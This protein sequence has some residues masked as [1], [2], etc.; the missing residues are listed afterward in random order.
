MTADPAREGEG[1]YLLGTED[2]ELRRLAFQ[3]RVWLRQAIELWERAGFGTGQ[4]LLDLGCGPGFAAIDLAHWVGP[5]GRIVAVDASRRFLDHLAAH[6]AAQGLGWIERVESD[7]YDL[8]LDEASLDGAYCRW[9]FCFLERPEAVLATL[10]RALRPGASLAI[11][12]YFNYRAFTLAP[13][14]PAFDRVVPEVENAWR[15]AG[16]DLGIQ[17]RMP[18]LLRRAG[19]EVIEVR[20]SARIA[21]PG[22]A[23]WQWPRT[24]FDGFLPRL[25]DEG[26]IN[27]DDAAR[28]DADWAARS[29]DPDAFL[30]LPPMFDLI[31]VKPPAG[32]R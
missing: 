25:V 27:A 17:G 14:S 3:H 9:L 31:A 24:F 28:F 13:R 15:A 20:S 19:L 29:A 22:S 21:R 16:G 5:R 1:T 26:R 23:L 12:D 6:A 18:A 7:V 8:E 11:T 10:T 32:R 30:C 4:T 2:E